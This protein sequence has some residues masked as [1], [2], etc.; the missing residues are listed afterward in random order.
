LWGCYSV[1]DHLEPRA[2]VA[3]LLLYDRLVVPVPTPKDRGRWEHLKWDPDRQQRLLETAAPFVERVEWDDDLRGQFSDRFSAAV[4]AE[5]IASVGRHAAGVDSWEMTRQMISEQIRGHVLESAP[6]GEVRAVSVYAQPD[7]FDREWRV[8]AVFPFVHRTSVVTPGRLREV[9]EPVAAAL[10]DLAHLVV[11]KLVVPDDGRDDVEVLRSTVALLKRKDV[12]SRRAEFQAVL[13][14]FYAEGLKDE[15]IVGEIDDLLT[16]YNNEIR[17]HADATKARAAIQL[18]A[19][20]ESAAA[21]W[22]PPM[23]LAVGPTTAVGEAV[24]RRNHGDAAPPVVGAV[25]L[26]SEART[27][28]KAD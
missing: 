10:Q 17:K 4:A 12:S 7:R 14:Q 8:D 24:I 9:R 25:A 13:G 11:T 20:A 22:V 16:A 5:E 3:D 1:R 15:T 6:T 28:L 19:F 23:S 27:A 21:L 18:V 26:L 2:F